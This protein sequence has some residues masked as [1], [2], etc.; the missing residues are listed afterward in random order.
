MR[1]RD[2]AVAVAAFGGVLDRREQVVG[3]PFE[4]LDERGRDA[5]RAGL[6]VDGR[7]PHLH[8]VLA[9]V[10][11][12]VGLGHRRQDVEQR[13]ALAVD[14][15]V[16]LLDEAHRQERRPAEQPAE[17][18]VDHR[19]LDHVLP[20]RG[21][22]VDDGD[23]AAGADGGAGG[24]D[25]LRAAVLDLVGGGGG[26]GVLVADGEAADL[27]RG[28]EIPL[29]QLRREVLDV[30]DVVVAGADGVGREPG[31]DVHVDANQVLDGGGVLGA[32]EALERTPARTRVGGGVL[33]HRAF[34]RVDHRAIDVASSGR[35]A[36]GGRHHPR[37]EL[38]D[39]LLGELAVLDG[40]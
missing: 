26:A 28:A 12:E 17:R 14:R 19:G 40:L 11:P 15:D 21:E 24:A 1:Q 5:L 20:V 30:G 34:E 29:H 18:G 27:A 31:V 8:P 25:H 36:L 23:A 16:Q 38:A 10:L 39:H 6:D 35:G 13:D 3:G 32:V 37:A 2:G 9:L 4:A 7:R 33:V 22:D